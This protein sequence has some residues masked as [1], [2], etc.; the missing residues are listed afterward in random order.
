MD[1]KQI[2]ITNFSLNVRN[3]KIHGQIKLLQK[4]IT[5]LILRFQ[6][7]FIIKYNRKRVDRIFRICAPKCTSM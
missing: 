7:M 1:I 4:Q 6:K 5:V 2:I 3:A